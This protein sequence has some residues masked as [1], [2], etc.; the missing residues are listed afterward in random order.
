[1]DFAKTLAKEFETK[2]T[3][4][5]TIITLLDEGNTIPF[6][7]RYRKEAHGTMDDQKIRAISDRLTYLRNL[8]LRRTEIAELISA[9][10]NMTEEI[11]AALERAVTLTELEDIYRPFRPKRKT[12]ASVAKEKGLEPL[13]KEI[14]ENEGTKLF[15]LAEKY[16]DAEKGV[17]T[18]DDALAGASD[19][20]A[21]AM[22]DN[23]DIRRRIR[24][25][26]RVN[27]FVVATSAKEDLGVYE[28]YKEFRESVAK[29]AGHRV[30]ALNRGEKEEFLRVKIEMDE[31]RPLAV[32]IGTFPTRCKQSAEFVDAAARDSYSRLIFPSIEREIRNELTDSASAGA[33][34]LFGTNLRQLLLQPP[35]KGKTVIGL[36]PG[37]R[38]GCKLAVVDMTGKVLDTAV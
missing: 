9:S 38:T 6:I 24:N 19:I 14:M 12:R 33:I 2:E 3:Y 30:L 1:M 28:M 29:I 22:S 35:V 31:E 4:I 13:A 7:A 17:E 16:I 21:E 10:D 26:T 20:I 11:A 32:I 5:D 25:L 27:G 8:E 36:D 34:K 23:A 18:V 15:A 37:F